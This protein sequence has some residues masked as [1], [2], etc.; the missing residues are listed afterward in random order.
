MNE[1]T[2]VAAGSSTRC[3]Q[4]VTT[5]SIWVGLV[6]VGLTATSL[7][8]FGMFY[9]GGLVSP[10]LAIVIA[11]PQ[12]L[13][14]A[15]L[16]LSFLNDSLTV[17]QRWGLAAGFGGILLIGAP[18]MSESKSQLLGIGCVLVAAVATA[19]SNVMLKSL[20]GLVDT[21]RAMGWQLLIGALPL[22]H[23]AYILEQAS[24]KFRS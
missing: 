14:A 9:G 3:L 4:A 16:A 8:F 2:D 18:R 11:N 15:A 13:I 6:V 19:V 22:A 17:L 1:V 23:L 12:P 7:G 20:V 24:L 5:R 10:G 21:L